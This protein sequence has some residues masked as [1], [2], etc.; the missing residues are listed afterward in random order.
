MTSEYS[1]LLTELLDRCK[2]QR[3]L[4]RLNEKP[5]TNPN[6]FGLKPICRQVGSLTLLHDFRVKGF[7]DCIVETE[8]NIFVIDW[9]TELHL[10]NED[11][12]MR[13]EIQLP[14]ILDLLRMN[15]M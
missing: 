12:I 13:Y 6:P 5:N 7:V 10:K 4:K 1:G 14:C 3:Y 9:K 8:N 11:E 2:I 15:T